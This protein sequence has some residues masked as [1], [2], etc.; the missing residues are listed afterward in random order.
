MHVLLAFFKATTTSMYAP[1]IYICIY[2]YI[3][4]ES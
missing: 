3:E 1:A 4:R 2:I